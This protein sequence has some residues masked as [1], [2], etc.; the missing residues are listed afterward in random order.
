MASS[1]SIITVTA[2]LFLAVIIS[3]AVKGKTYNNAIQIVI[4]IA[5]LAGIALYG[6]GFS[7]VDADQPFLAVIKSLV[8]LATM[9]LGRNSFSEIADTP[10][11][12]YTIVQVVFW[13]AH[14]AAVYSFAGTIIVNMG[15]NVLSRLRLLMSRRGELVVIYGVND[16]SVSLTKTLSEKPNTSIFFI[17]KAADAD[18]DMIRS[19]GC[20]LYEND[21]DLIPTPK[22][23]KKMGVKSN[24]K[25][26]LYCIQDSK[27]QNILFADAF[28]KA[29]E[30]VGCDPQKTRLVIGGYEEAIGDRF[31]VLAG[32]KYGFG[33]VLAYDDHMMTARQLICQNPP[34][35]TMRFDENCR[36]EENF[37]ALVI[38]F[39]QSGMAALRY[40]LLNGMFEGSEFKA[41]V[42][43]S[44]CDSV[45]GRIMNHCP[46]IREYF[47]VTF[48]NKNAKSQEFYE[49]L[50]GHYK[51]LKYI[52]LC[53]GKTGNEELA[54]EISR[55]LRFHNKRL[56]VYC[57]TKD[58]YIEIKYWDTLPV[59]WTLYDS[60]ILI[61]DR[62]DK[63][64]MA[65]N[66][67][68]CQGNGKTML[69][70]WFTCDSFSRE[71]SRAAADFMPSL[72]RMAGLTEK[73]VLE[74]GLSLSS[75]QELNLA[76]TEHLR[77]CS[78]HLNNGFQ[79]MSAAEFDDRC[80]QY[81]AEKSAGKKPAVR[82][83]KNMRAHTHACLVDWDA[84]NA[85]SE[86]EKAVT[87]QDVDYRQVDINNI[88]VIP[89]AL[90]LVRE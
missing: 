7:V 24:R 88:R 25:L 84:L 63:L 55:F 66:H 27:S 69:E 86:A 72:L 37:E 26:T 68:Y 4:L 35:D 13:L 53:C 62:A 33:N 71:S 57:L 40:L 38:G 3:L 21:D 54:Y 19:L 70:N 76:K 89:L 39:G 10:L 29:M 75:E 18:R 12:Q 43:A 59:G 36:A 56:P 52:V 28:M 65:Y 34:V 46:D 2:A 15:E 77:W 82:I 17:G 8:A 58:E 22:V 6:Y 49:F 23:L 47:H 90:K 67:Y 74:N 32:E 79:P 9:Y 14:F 78:F 73:E 11:M 61:S 83:T 64:A 30:K 45:S 5:G 60:D 44:D 48:H 42:F 50:K 20:S 85:L 51:T 81:L 16:N 80:K 87:G 41:D 1:I 31:Q